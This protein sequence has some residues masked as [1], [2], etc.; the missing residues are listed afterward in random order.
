MPEVMEREIQRL[1]SLRWSQAI[2]YDI[3]MTNPEFKFVEAHC[4]NSHN[5]ASLKDT[6]K[7]VCNE[8]GYMP[9]EIAYDKDCTPQ[10]NVIYTLKRTILGKIKKQYFAVFV[11]KGGLR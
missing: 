11:D 2:P 7:Q 3:Y 4:N 5:L 6:Y 10:I 1:M 9:I 8:Y